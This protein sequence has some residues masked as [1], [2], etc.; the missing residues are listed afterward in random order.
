VKLLTHGLP[1]GIRMLEVAQ[2]C[3]EHDI[4][5]LIAFARPYVLPPQ[6]YDGPRPEP[7]IIMV[8]GRM[9]LRRL[10]GKN[11]PGP[12]PRRRMLAIVRDQDFD[13]FRLRF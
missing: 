3:R 9:I 1:P 2:W 4:P 7:E 12:P 5:L 6:E 8:T 11:S 10:K 13:L